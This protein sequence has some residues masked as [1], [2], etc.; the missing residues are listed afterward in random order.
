M[1]ST[2]IVVNVNQ[3]LMTNKNESC[4][5]LENCN[6][7]NTSIE[8]DANMMQHEIHQNNIADEGCSANDNELLEDKAALDRR[9]NMIGDPVPSVVKFDIENCIFNCAPAAKS[10]CQNMFYL[11]MILNS[12]HSLIYFHMDVGDI[13]TLIEV[14][15]C[16]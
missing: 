11:M 6:I 2:P 16:P 9:Q 8:S 7:H 4:D 14:L 13:I 3:K 10:T 1:T 12:L 15:K 5:T